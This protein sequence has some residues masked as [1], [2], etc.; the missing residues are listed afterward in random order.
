MADIVQGLWIGRPLSVLERLSM[1]SFLRHGHEYHL[2]C[3]DDVRDVPAGVVIRDGNEILPASGIFSYRHGPGR[4]SLSA[5]SNLFRYKLLLER[6]GWW[7]DADA[8]CLRPWDFELPIVLASEHTRDAKAKVAN[9]VMKL[10]A[11]HPVAAMC[12]E[13]A[14]TA[15]RD[16]LQWG[17][18]GSNLVT[19]ALVENDL[20]H[21][22]MKPEVFCP[23]SWWDW[24]LVL[25]GESRPAR[26]LIT[27]DCYSVHLWHE[28]WRRAGFLGSAAIPPTSLL[29]Q[30]LEHF[31]VDS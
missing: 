2:Y 18:I 10:P 15:D 22:I 20:M 19:R 31:G 30:L 23:I 17:E 7:A 12:Y 21:V 8:V 11:G 9:G 5:F 6:G 16:T 25:A 28:M 29:G 14:S 3:Y 13:A 26:E 27:G 24:T 4:G 1:T